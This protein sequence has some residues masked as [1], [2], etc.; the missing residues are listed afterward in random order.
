[1]PQADLDAIVS[2]AQI[3]AARK[4]LGWSY[5]TLAKKA[6]RRLRLVGRV[7]EELV[8]V[9]P[10]DLANTYVALVEILEA[11]GVRFDEDKRGVRLRKW[12]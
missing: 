4:L 6:R 8:D 3:R 1:M 10:D 12:T 11:A 9:V 7:E 5:A 2:G